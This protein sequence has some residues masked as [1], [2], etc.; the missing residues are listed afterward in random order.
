MKTTSV[1]IALLSA[2]AT[3]SPAL[4]L[5]VT[6]LNAAVKSANGQSA[7]AFEYVSRGMIANSGVG[8]VPRVLIAVAAWN[9]EITHANKGRQ[10]DENRAY[11]PV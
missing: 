3:A 5:E 7:R 6:S 8:I 4:E 1:F 11:M 2:V 10:W 9:A